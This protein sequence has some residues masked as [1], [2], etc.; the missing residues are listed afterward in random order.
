MHCLICMGFPKLWR[1][2]GM[3]QKQNEHMC[4]YRDLNPQ[5]STAAETYLKSERNGVAMPYP[6]E[7]RLPPTLIVLHG[8]R[9]FWYSFVVDSSRKA[10]VSELRTMSIPSV[11]LLVNTPSVNVMKLYILSYNSTFEFCRIN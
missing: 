3:E 9:M 1:R 2:T 10:Y 7:S 4:L 6:L 5:S 8:F 11:V